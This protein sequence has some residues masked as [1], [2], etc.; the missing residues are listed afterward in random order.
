MDALRM[1]AI[2]HGRKT[3][4]AELL[5]RAIIV[6]VSSGFVWEGI[7]EDDHLAVIANRD[8]RVT[9]SYLHTPN[10]VDN[11]HGTEYR[12]SAEGIVANV[13]VHDD[14]GSWSR[15][16]DFGDNGTLVA[17]APGNDLPAL[18]Q[19]L[20]SRIMASPLFTTLFWQRCPLDRLKLQLFDV[21]GHR[22]A[23]VWSINGVWGTT[24]GNT[25]RNKKLAMID[26]EE[27]ARNHLSSAYQARLANLLEVTTA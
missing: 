15:Y 8:Y 17:W 14:D 10:S 21:D 24:V 27:S 23:S 7:N 19:D 3:V 1:Y 16:R 5:H 4:I 6:P 18:V 26:A 2:E 12:L 9:F 25:H 11:G 13:L 20:A 22:H